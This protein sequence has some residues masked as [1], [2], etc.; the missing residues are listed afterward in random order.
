MN[1][2]KDKSVMEREFNVISKTGAVMHVY[3]TSSIEA[4]EIAKSV[5]LNV[6]SCFEVE[7]EQP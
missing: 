4:S 6:A 1:E 3:A 7:S 2:T 5:G